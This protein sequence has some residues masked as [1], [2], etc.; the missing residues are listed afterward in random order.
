MNSRFLRNDNFPRDELTDALWCVVCAERFHNLIFSQFFLMIG[1]I[2]A[3]EKQEKKKIRKIFKVLRDFSHSRRLHL[4][5]SLWSLQIFR[6]SFLNNQIKIS[7]TRH[8]HDRHECST[9]SV[10]IYFSF[11]SH[12]YLSAS[13]EFV[14]R[15]RVEVTQQQR[16]SW[17]S[18]DHSAF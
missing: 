11:P 10:S 4:T 9:S 6:Y 18:E 8:H 1:Q 14:T 12:I 7:F 5:S 16:T 13:I 15:S 2:A 3:D 17:R